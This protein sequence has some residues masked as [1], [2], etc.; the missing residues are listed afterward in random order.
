MYKNYLRFQQ[1]LCVHAGVLLGILYTCSMGMAVGK[2]LPSRYMCCLTVVCV[3]QLV[4][5]TLHLCV[6]LNLYSHSHSHSHVT[7]T[8]INSSRDMNVT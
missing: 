6:L 7:H 8:F 3:V 1:Q 4:L 2:V 5:C